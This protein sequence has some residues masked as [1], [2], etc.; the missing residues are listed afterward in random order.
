MRVGVIAGFAA[1][2][3]ATS[4]AVAT[5]TSYPVGTM[6][7]VTHSSPGTGTLVRQPWVEG[8]DPVM[9]N[10]LFFATYSALPSH[11]VIKVYAF[12]GGGYESAG[13]RF[14]GRVPHEDRDLTI[15]E[16][17]DEAAVLIR[18]TFERF[19][20]VQHVD[21]WATIPVAQSEARAVE[22][23][24]FSVSAD[25]STYEQIADRTDMSTLGFVGAFGRLWIAPQVPR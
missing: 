21:I 14:S 20:E 15:E 18:T 13:I 16:L 1:F 8:V 19:P 3:A 2:I 23:T 25:R 10:R 4:S 6:P 22:N 17:S 12:S 24:V 9:E 11:N 7:P 5:P